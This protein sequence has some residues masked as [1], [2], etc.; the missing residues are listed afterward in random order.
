MEK[1]QPKIEIKKKNKG[2]FTKWC[3]D[4]GHKSVTSACEEEGLASKYGSVRK[5]AQFSK[6]A[7]GWKK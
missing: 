7:K 2:K 4:H 5:M 6:N 1:K 3:K